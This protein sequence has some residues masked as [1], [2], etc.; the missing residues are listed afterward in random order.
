LKAEPLADSK[1]TK[2]ICE[3]IQQLASLK[4]LKKGVN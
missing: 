4:Q 3:L 2:K 1:L